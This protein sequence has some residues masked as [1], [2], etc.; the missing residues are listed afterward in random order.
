VSTNP[1]SEVLLE[2]TPGEGWS[3]GR[4]G[5][6]KSG[7]MFDMILDRTERGVKIKSIRNRSQRVSA[8]APRRESYVCLHQ[9]LSEI[10]TSDQKDGK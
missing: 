7:L 10:S 3:R 5:R 9:K 1:R 4:P 2:V 6:A 8:I